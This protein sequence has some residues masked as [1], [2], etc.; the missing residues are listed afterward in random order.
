M[1][2]LIVRT[3]RWTLLLSSILAASC[4][5]PETA[6][7]SRSQFGIVTSDATVLANVEGSAT[8]FTNT[9]LTDLI[10]KGVGKA[11]VIQCDV[12]SDPA[13]SGPRMVWHVINEGTEPTA[14]ISVHLVR[15]GKITRSAFTD[16]SAPGS[17]PDA[18][19]MDTI[20]QLAQRVLPPAAEHSR[21]SCS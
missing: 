2:S 7:D 15:D 1:M 13:T 4:A 20:S 10:R 6:G 16:A 21:P 3:A 17:S 12:S 18:V 11:Y 14:V 9:E 19:F 8:G 5:G